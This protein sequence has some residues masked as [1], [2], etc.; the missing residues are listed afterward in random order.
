M[1]G[2]ADRPDTADV[3]AAIAL[4]GRGVAAATTMIRDVHVALA[5]RA[6]TLSG[7][8][9]KPVQLMHDAISTTVYAAVGGG[10]R[11][12]AAATGLA[13]AA[14]AATDPAYL[15]LSQRPRGNVVIGAINGAWGD[16]LDRTRSP[17]ALAMTVRHDHRDVALTTDAVAQAYP[18]AT[19]DVAVWLHGLC[20]SDIA[21]RLKATDHYGDAAST[22]GARL[23]NEC[24]L[25]PVYLRYNTGLHI[26]HNGRELDRLLTD[27]VAA[28]PVPVTRLTLI[29]HSMGGLVI[30]SAGLV[31]CESES[32]WVPLV[33]RVVYLGAPHLGA[34]LEVGANRA[35]RALR[36]LPETKPL[37]DALASRSVGIKDLRYGDVRDVD[38]AEVTDWEAHRPEPSECAPLLA[39]ADHYFI[40]AT[41]GQR[42]DTPVAR[43]LGDALVPFAS[44]SG[45]GRGRTLG[46]D[47]DRGRHLGGLHHFDLLNHPRVYAVLRDWLACAPDG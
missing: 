9:A 33:K 1:A 18:D 17:L 44:A 5:R 38:W 35:A 2:M 47:V 22:H 6:F 13:V 28:W 4:A 7:P 36:R 43:I 34:P 37:A 26:S 30:R 3:R 20:E 42:H 46:L 23:Q 45:T 29:G 41:I 16:W 8:P 24:G 27:L 25:T 32:P 14:R 40:G 10:A 21:W 39:E 12:A 31:G 15:P 19:G 11:A